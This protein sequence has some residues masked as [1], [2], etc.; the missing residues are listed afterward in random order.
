MEIG[1]IVAIGIGGA[2]V[3]LIANSRNRKS[4]GQQYTNSV[5]PTATTVNTC[6]CTCCNPRRTPMGVRTIAKAGACAPVSPQCVNPRTP[7]TVGACAPVVCTNVPVVKPPVPTGVFTQDSGSQVVVA[8]SDCTMVQWYNGG[9]QMIA[10]TTVPNLAA[11]T[12]SLGYSAGQVIDHVVLIG[13]GGSTIVINN[14]APSTNAPAPSPGTSVV[15]NTFILPPVFRN[16]KLGTVLPIISASAPFQSKGPCV[17][18][19]SKA[20]PGG[21][22]PTSPVPL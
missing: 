1:D 14:L 7:Q 6:Y 5:Q 8:I 12:A 4:Q 10:Q 3:Y 16:T 2:I 19:T 21:L 18:A 9:K 11:T 13:P 15:K 17:P 20:V 22:S